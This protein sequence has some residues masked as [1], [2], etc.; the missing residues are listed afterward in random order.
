MTIA[1]H[2]AAARRALESAGV[3]PPE[4]GLDAD[5]LARHVLGWDRAALVARRREEAPAE[6]AAAYPALVA[7]R[8]ARE[9]VAYILGEREF[10]G[11][12]F[13]VTPEVLVPRPETEL[14]VE[15]ALVA[16]GGGPPPATVIDVCTGS[17]CLAVVLA[18]EFGGA[19]V[20]ATDISEAALAVARR[21]AQRHHVA[22][23]IAFRAADL[24]DGVSA[25]ADLIVSN[26]PYVARRDAAALPPEV[27]DHEPHVALF[28]GDDGLEVYRRLLPAARQR[29]TQNGRLVIEI[30]QH[31]ADPVTELADAARLRLDHTRQDLQRITRTMVFAPQ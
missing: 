27:R 19:D 17:G 24:L 13:E 23:R 25:R 31:Q 30:G 14:I 1:E 10:W 8:A 22:A 12:A 29:L 2:L 15:E 4:A 21:N 20:V 7:R 6:F 16:F 28:A 5:L 3:A 18:R 26:P 9:P 11:L